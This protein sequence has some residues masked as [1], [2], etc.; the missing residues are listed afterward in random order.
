MRTRIEM[1]MPDEKMA[2]SIVD[3]LN[4]SKK[5]NRGEVLIKRNRDVLILDVSSPDLTAM[6]SALNSY[7][8]VIDAIIN[9]WEVVENGRSKRY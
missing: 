5:I 2:H 4:I 7:L 1:R 8:R 6:R 9:I 3:A